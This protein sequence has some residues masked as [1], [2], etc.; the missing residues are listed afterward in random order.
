MAASGENRFKAAVKAGIDRDYKKAILLLE[1]LI[2]ETDAPPEA[3]LLLGRSFHST[4]D[5]SH[6]LV[7]Y[8]DFI[9]LKPGS[10]LGYFFA[11]RTYLALALP[12]KAVPLLQKALSIRKN[13]PLIMAMLG[14]A[15][16][17]S[18][19]SGKAVE[20]LENAVTAAPE[21][22]R[23]YK[24]YLNALFIR[25]IK[26]CRAGDLDLGSQILSFL[27]VNGVDNPLLRLELGMA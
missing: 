15:Y 1:Q 24:A 9:R 3:Y 14:A 26:L 4:G 13:D 25:G 27:L 22:A 12:Q 20:I 18:R 21:N 19:H 8:G 23:I 17:K 6:A 11:G 5:Y 10:A 7:A 16:L 2:S